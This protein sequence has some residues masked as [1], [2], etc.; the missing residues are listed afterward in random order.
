MTYKGFDAQ[1]TEI[2]KEV[3]RLEWLQDY[4]LEWR[5]HAK[6]QSERV[7]ISQALTNINAEI[8]F[9]EEDTFYTTDEASAL[10]TE[11]YLICLRG[12]MKALNSF[13][14]EQAAEILKGQIRQIEDYL[15]DNPKSG[16]IPF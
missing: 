3:K 1:D 15:I 6:R 5:L 2:E 12:H 16:W 9:P 7:E 8:G 4:F 14:F 13:G 11:E 10:L